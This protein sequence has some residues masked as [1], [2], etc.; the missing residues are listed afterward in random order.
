[1][2]IDLYKLYGGSDYAGEEVTQLQHMLQAGWLARENG[3]SP[4]VILAAFLHDIGHICMQGPDVQTMNE[5]GIKDHEEIGSD[6]LLQNGFS[7]EIRELVASHVEA[8]RY[9]TFRDP[10][11]YDSLSNASRETLNFQGGPMNDT[12]AAAFE[13]RKHFEQIINLRKWDDL[14]KNTESYPEDLDY[15]H[16]LIVEHLIHQ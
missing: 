1:E 8:K 12:E 4:D 3:S 10:G 13:I 2:I 15:Y 5:F 6:Y 9:L 7:S 16:N 11:Y 14:A